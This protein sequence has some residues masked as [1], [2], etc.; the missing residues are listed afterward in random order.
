MREW[1]DLIDARLG[2]ETEAG[3]GTRLCVHLES[4]ASRL[5]TEK[6]SGLPELYGGIV[7]LCGF[8][9]ICLNID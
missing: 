7:H 8:N 3:K 6:R 2:V 5:R 1:A 4:P 9:A